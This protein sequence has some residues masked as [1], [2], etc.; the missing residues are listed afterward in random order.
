MNRMAKIGRSKISLLK[1]F[2]PL[3]RVGAVE[4]LK[5]VIEMWHTYVTPFFTY[6][7]GRCVIF[8]ENGLNVIIT[9]TK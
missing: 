6:K 1:Y 4:Q 8:K 5:A 7:E 9:L 2:T 3:I